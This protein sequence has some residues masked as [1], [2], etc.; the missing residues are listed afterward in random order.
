MTRAQKQDDRTPEEIARTRGFWVATDRF[1]SGWGHA[2]GRSL[3]ACPVFDGDDYHT[4]QR[5]FENRTDF[6]RVRFCLRNYRPRLHP[7]DHLHIYGG[8]SFRP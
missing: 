8:S 7:G 2:P 5:V 1:M 3:V 6:Q 4:V